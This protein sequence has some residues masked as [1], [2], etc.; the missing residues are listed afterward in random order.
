[1]ILLLTGKANHCVCDVQ[2]NHSDVKQR[3]EESLQRNSYWL[4]I[5]SALAFTAKLYYMEM[6]SHPLEI[7]TE[8]RPV[9]YY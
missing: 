2:T 5:Q 9:Y 4:K 8:L 3:I 1:M 7:Q 6:L